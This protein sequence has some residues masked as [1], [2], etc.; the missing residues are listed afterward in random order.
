MLLKFA[1]N[2]YVISMSFP[3]CLESVPAP[4]TTENEGEESH[5]DLQS[6]FKN[7]K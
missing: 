5:T 2:K 4:Y 1:R 3:L 7:C 6:A